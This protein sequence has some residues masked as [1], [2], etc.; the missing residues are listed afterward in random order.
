VASNVLGKSGRDMVEA[1]I[2]GT[3]DV[4]VLA[5]LARGSLRK[6]IPQLQA[7]LEGRLQ[8]HHRLLLGQMLAHIDFL[9]ASLDQ[10]QRLL[11][12]P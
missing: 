4:A 7:A 5:D 6:K 8:P 3:T 11:I 9:E 1:L 2:R 10:V 12:G